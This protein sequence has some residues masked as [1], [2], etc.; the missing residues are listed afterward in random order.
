MTLY[1]TNHHQRLLGNKHGS[2]D[3]LTTSEDSDASSIPCIEITMSL[4]RKGMTDCAG[5]VL[6]FLMTSTTAVSCASVIT[7][8]SKPLTDYVSDFISMNFLG[9]AILCIVLAGFSSTPWIVGSMDAF[10]YVFVK[11]ASFL[12]FNDK[13]VS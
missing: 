11:R 2:H 13:I 4:L 10:M 3:S 7:G 12:S 1:G 5:G 8:H 6:I 9:T